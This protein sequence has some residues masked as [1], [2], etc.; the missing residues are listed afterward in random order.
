[1]IITVKRIIRTITIIIIAGIQT[2]LVAA[3]AAAVLPTVAA[4]LAIRIAL[5]NFFAVSIAEFALLINPLPLFF[6]SFIN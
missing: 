4:V 6:C 2:S 3:A 1:M 5:L